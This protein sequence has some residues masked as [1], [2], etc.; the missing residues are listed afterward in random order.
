[1]RV[2]RY[3][4]IYKGETFIYELS[5]LGSNLYHGKVHENINLT[6]KLD[7]LINVQ[8]ETLSP[9][10]LNLNLSDTSFHLKHLNCNSVNPL[11]F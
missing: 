7:R 2:I 5:L 1:M 10:T 4:S 8:K 3:T 11:E 6:S 9:K